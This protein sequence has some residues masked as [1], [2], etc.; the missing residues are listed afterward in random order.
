MKKQTTVAL[1][2]F[3]CLSVSIIGQTPSP[4]P[5]TQQTD[6][7]VVRITANLVQ[8]DAVV[9]DVKGRLVTDLRQEEIEIRED[10]RPQK[11]TN[12][13]F[14]SV[15]PSITKPNVSNPDPINKNYPPAPPSKLI[16]EDLRRTFALVVDGPGIAFEIILCQHKDA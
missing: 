13:S 14:I 11:S 1:G 2:L 8:V 9:T 3:L 15:E 12:F 4:T 16:P 7:D 6:S 10:D 5:Q